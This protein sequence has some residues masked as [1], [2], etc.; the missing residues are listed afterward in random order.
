MAE[1]IVTDLILRI[2]EDAKEFDTR[3]WVAAVAVGK[4]IYWFS[5]SS[6]F[7]AVSIIE[8]ITLTVLDESGCLIR[9]HKTVKK[10]WRKEV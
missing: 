4:F 3:I 5:L 7:Q 6:P 10:S 2:M 9:N 1:I 8:L